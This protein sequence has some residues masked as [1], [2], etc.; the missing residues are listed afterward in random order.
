MNALAPATT[1]RL[2]GVVARMLPPPLDD[3]TV[4]REGADSHSPLAPSVLTVLDRM[5]K[6]RNNE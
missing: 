5:A 3:E 6:R 2:L 1:T 4:R